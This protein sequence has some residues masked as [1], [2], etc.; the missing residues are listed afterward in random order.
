MLPKFF[1]SLETEK[2]R[3][4]LHSDGSDSPGYLNFV[5]PITDYVKNNFTTQDKG[6][7][8]GAGHSVV[9]ADLLNESSLNVKIFDPFFHNFQELLNDKYDYIIACE[10]VEHFHNPLKEFTLLYSML[11][12]NGKL[13]IMTDPLRETTIFSNWYYKNDETHVFFYSLKTFQF[14]KEKF[15]FKELMI[16]DRL[17]VLKK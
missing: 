8:F 9:I 3:Y 6:L 7:D 12:P 17:I 15:Q 2:N 13:I 10:V 14:I 11:N 5:K 4:E 1:V 16:N